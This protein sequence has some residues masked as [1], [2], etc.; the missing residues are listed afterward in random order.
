MQNMNA[1]R[2][3]NSNDIW[4]ACVALFELHVGTLLVRFFVQVDMLH[5][6]YNTVKLKQH[7]E[8]VLNVWFVLNESAV[9][10]K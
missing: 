6:A 7:R 3:P 1:R 10:G 4:M 8:I 2:Y 5:L 9:Q